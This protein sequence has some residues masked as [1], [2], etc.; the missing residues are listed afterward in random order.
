MAS[1]ITTQKESAGG[2]F[3]CSYM[4]NSPEMRTSVVAVAGEPSLTSRKNHPPDG[5]RETIHTWNEHPN[6]ALALSELKKL[7]GV[8]IAEG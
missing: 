4:G 1:K 2:S 3:S 8:T 7:S 6:R 5:A